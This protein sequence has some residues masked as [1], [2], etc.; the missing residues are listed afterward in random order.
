MGIFLRC[1]CV[2]ILCQASDS[3]VSVRSS[4]EL[5]RALKLQ[6]NDALGPGPDALYKSLLDK[7]QTSTLKVEQELVSID[8]KGIGSTIDSSLSIVIDIF[9]A[10]HLDG[11]SKARILDIL[12]VNHHS[13][14][15]SFAESKLALWHLIEVAAASPFT[16]PV[17]TIGYA[18]LLVFGGIGYDDSKVGSPYDAGTKTYSVEE[19]ERFYGA[20][21]LFVLRRLLKLASITGAFNL[22]L[23]FDWRTA[24]V[25]KNQA[26]RAKEA[27]TLATQLGPTFI[28]LGQALS[29][30]T[31]L[32]PEAY[33]LELRQLQDAVPPFDSAAAY[34]IIKKEMGIRKEIGEKFRSISPLPVASASIGQVYRGTLLDGRDVAVK[35]QRPKVLGEIAL[36]LYL[37]RLITPLQVKLTNAINGQKTEQ[38]DIDVAISLVDEWG[39]GFVAEVDYKLEAKNTKQF[40]LAM[41]RRG[42]NAVTAPTVVDELSGSKVLVTE[43]VE[44]TRLDRDASSDVPRCGQRLC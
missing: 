8:F 26:E 23:L 41:E 18:L 24:Q 37:L 39:R 43:W 10:I 38:S 14:G 32:I 12:S 42:L 1:L 9:N 40:S 21:P 15:S 11:N 36:D 13:T 3:F 34:D 28:K 20:R 6:L 25:E 7:F 44:G 5:S 2:L 27:L 22:K 19:A 17:F 33:A 30:R 31:D 29:I 35:V 4:K 16:L